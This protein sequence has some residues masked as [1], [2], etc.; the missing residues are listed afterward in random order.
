MYG[1]IYV[2]FN[3]SDVGVDEINLPTF[4]KGEN[5]DASIDSLR[6]A[7]AGSKVGYFH[8]AANTNSDR[9]ITVINGRLAV[10]RRVDINPL[11][12][13]LFVEDELGA[14]KPALVELHFWITV[15]P[16]QK[17]S[18]QCGICQNAKSGATISRDPT[19]SGSNPNRIKILIHGPT[20][21]SARELLFGILQGDNKPEKPWA[22]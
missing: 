9:Y 22:V 2:H 17:R 20:I 16:K 3:P 6:V 12:L 1:T 7:I 21:Q 13:R 19:T 5:H 10:N 18:L 11:K 8:P 15:N 4:G 14:Y